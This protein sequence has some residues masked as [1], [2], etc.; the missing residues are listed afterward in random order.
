MRSATA[1]AADLLS[2]VAEPRPDR[3]VCPV[4]ADGGDGVVP[5]S[6]I[7]SRAR[8]VAT[9][10]RAGGLRPGDVACTILPGGPDFLAAVFGTL[11]AGGVASPLPTPPLLASDHYWDHL[12]AM[13]ALARPRVL[14]TTRAVA[15][16]ERLAKATRDCGAAVLA[17]PDAAV[18]AESDR[19]RGTDLALVQFTSG[20]SGPPKGIRIT[21]EN[22]RAN[23]AALRKAMLISAEDTFTTWLP[24]YHDMGFIAQFLPAAAQ[25][26]NYVVQPSQF[27]RDPMTWLRCLGRH[28]ATLT[29]AP[30]FGY[31]YCA[32]RV[33]TAQLTGL[34]F[35]GVKCAVIGAERISPS[36]VS[37]FSA[38]LRTFGLR[39]EALLPAYGLGEATL[40]VTMKRPAAALSALPV[41]WRAAD[42]ADAGTAVPAGPVRHA[43]EFGHQAA[44]TWVM[45]CGTP[46]DGCVVQITDDDLRAVAD[47]VLGEIVVSG[48]S[49]AEGYAAGSGAGSLTGFDAGRLRTGDVGLMCQGELYVVGRT[50]DSIKVNGR[51]LYAEQVELE[52]CRAVGRG[53]PAERCAALLGARDGAALVALVAEA[54]IGEWVDDAAALLRRI[55]G[56]A[57]IEIY[58][59]TRGVIIRTTSGKPARR[60]MWRQLARGTL[61]VRLLHETEAAAPPLPGPGRPA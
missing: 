39:A 31:R 11:W 33:T 5:Y 49:V 51:A 19:V 4:G 58:A 57:R 35:T 45:S 8:S 3:G 42:A 55:G 13:L 7:A 21:G 54:P 32:S 50:G 6:E 56:G 20:S 9:A 25:I 52:V 43:A 37:A 40:A 34:D 23:V 18:A 53:L 44:E 22:L 59:G 61:S 1:A 12:R 48:P 30:V 41:D 46:V 26:G 14:L 29:A 60:L 27:V 2:W 47:G 16:S 28:G 38:L 15:A 24:P 36:T 10:L 17:V